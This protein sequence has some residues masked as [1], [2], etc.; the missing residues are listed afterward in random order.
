MNRNKK[1]TRFLV[2]VSVLVVLPWVAQAWGQAAAPQAPSAAVSP[3]AP[4]AG[5]QSQP[6][7]TYHGNVKSRVFHKPGC[8]QYNCKNCTA[9]LKSR[10]EAVKAGYK[11]C[12]MCKP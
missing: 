1:L 9:V 8:Q 4:A 10:E 6:A 5:A 11:P 2:L 12:G 3:E 7:L